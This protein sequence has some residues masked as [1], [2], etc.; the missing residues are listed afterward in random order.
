VRI[1]YLIPEFP[2]QTHNFFW[3]ERAVLVEMGISVDIFSTRLP[4]TRNDTTS[5]GWEAKGITNYLYPVQPL[6]VGKDFFL[7]IL[8]RPLGIA[9]WLSSIAR[10]T[11]TTVSQK[12]RLLALGLLGIQLGRR[13]RERGIGHVHVHSCGDAANIA[14][15][16][17]LTTGISYSLTLHN[18]LSAYG[19]NQPEK[20]RHAKFSIVIA[21]WILADLRQKIP[22][23]LP[24]DIRLAPMGVDTE[25]FTR[26]NPYNFLGEKNDIRIFCCA[27]L[28]PGKGYLPLIE[29][30]GKLIGEGRRVSLVIAGEDDNGGE[31]YRKVIEKFI[32]DHDLIGDVTLLGGVTEEAVI[33]QLELASIFVLASMEEPLGVA[34]MEAMSMG[35]PV[36]A[37][38]AGGVPELIENRIDGWLVTPGSV[39][40][41]MEAII[42]VVES[43]ADLRRVTERAREKIIQ[44]FSHRLSPRAISDALKYRP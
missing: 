8:T 32:V 26:T 44:N 9:K 42:E 20:W 19:T 21:N 1:A 3:R 13:M 34:I 25:K 5:W 31:G 16:A 12:V 23:Y 27:R 7:V 37:T 39:N 35:V 43:P 41:L 29:A 15:F 28:N 33:D 18:P 11:D 36:I 30:T 40:S 6:Q 38:N 17:H 22:N 2:G 14:L 10:S 24:S 4:P